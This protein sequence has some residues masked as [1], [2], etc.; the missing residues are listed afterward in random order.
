MKVF[1]NFKQPS[2][3]ISFLSSKR[4]LHCTSIFNSDSSSHKNKNESTRRVKLRKLFSKYDSDGDGVLRHGDISHALSKA[5]PTANISQQHLQQMISVA[6]TDN[7]GSIDFNEFECLFDD[8]N[9]KD[10]SLIAL[11]DKW[12]GASDPDV[13]EIIFKGCWEKL[14]KIFSGEQ[15]IILPK[16]MLFLAGAPGAGKGVNSPAILEK[17]GLPTSTVVV[18]DLLN[19]PAAQKIKDSGGLCGDFEVLEAL[20]TKL[21][22]DQYKEGVLIDGYPRT[23]GQV[24]CLRRLYDKMLLLHKTHATTLRGKRDDH[25]STQHH[26]ISFSPSFESMVKVDNEFSL[27]R[28]RLVVLYVDEGVSIAR[29]ITRGKNSMAKNTA[30]RAEHEKKLDA[31]RAEHPGKADSELELPVFDE[32]LFEI[33]RETDVSVTHARHRYRVFQEKTMNA[34]HTLKQVWP[35]NILDASGSIEEV[36]ESIQK[37]LAYQSAMELRPET[38]EKLKS[39]PTASDVLRHARIKLVERL[40]RYSEEMPELFKDVVTLVENEFVPQLYI[41]GE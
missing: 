4:S 28:F 21:T 16:E 9:T 31:I 22:E 39:L 2:R 19:S 13:P 27:P 12:L 32:R 41:H 5:F 20:L 15:N 34:L 14:C 8:I 40:D 24:E 11:G 3:I 33:V 35:M 30:L 10:L 26:Q 38:Y 17:R 23:A 6:D 36:E 18:S 37:E 7:N 1:H 29:Q 25:S